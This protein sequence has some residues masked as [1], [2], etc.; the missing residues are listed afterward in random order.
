MSELFIYTR[1]L[2]IIIAI[3]SGA[4]LC[5]LGARLFQNG[6]FGKSDLKFEYGKLKLHLFKAT[7]GIFFS[8]FGAVI[9][10]GAVWRS[11]TFSEEFQDK[12]GFSKKTSIVKSIEDDAAVSN[13]SALKAKFRQA[14]DFHLN[15]NIAQAEVLYQEILKS[16][17]I[18]G[19][20]A[21]NLA[22]IQ[23]NRGEA[24]QAL[25]LAS[26]AALLFPDSTTFQQTLRQVKDL[27]EKK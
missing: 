7:P 22:D 8:L 25:I 12:S 5:Y 10:S 20:T 1:S 6:F 26:Y 23:K 19:Q 16:V 4:F 11:A 18:I 21:N 13:S 17:P 24:N 3:L 2:E 9:I 15:G 14:L 27:Q